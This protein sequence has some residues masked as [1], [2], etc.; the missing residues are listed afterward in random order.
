MSDEL[1]F[2]VVTVNA[3]LPFRRRELFVGFLGFEDGSGD[4]VLV[5]PSL[6]SQLTGAAR[7]ALPDE[8][9]GLVV[10]RAFRDSIGPYTA[11]LGAVEA[12]PEAGGRGTFTM[13]AELVAELRDLAGQ[14]FP[15]ADVVG[16]W[17]CHSFPSGFSS[18]DFRTQ[19]LWTLPT[20][21]GLLV[22]ARGPEWAVA[23]HGPEARLLRTAPAVAAATPTPTSPR[24]APQGTGQ[25]PASPR[26]SP[27]WT[28][29]GLQPSPGRAGPEPMRALSSGPARLLPQAVVS[30]PAPEQFVEVAGS[31][32]PHDGAQ[33]HARRS[34]LPALIVTAVAVLATLSLLLLDGSTD[35]GTQAAAPA[36]VSLLCSAVADASPPEFRCVVTAPGS[37]RIEWEVDGSRAS[38][39]RAWSIPKDLVDAHAVTVRVIGEDGRVLARWDVADMVRPMAPATISRPAAAVVRPGPT[40]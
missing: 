11:V 24:P 32:D 30:A 20:H 23:Y 16:W 31:F 35:R 22:L 10:G 40:P 17:H 36:A 34:R 9:G 12:P 15:E 28:S 3:D 18:V 2:T 39:D 37:S 27:T 33:H 38:S 5:D 4:L 1:E 8:T 6:R 25:P 14:Q 13:P 19:R 7:R 29:A 26:P 21:V